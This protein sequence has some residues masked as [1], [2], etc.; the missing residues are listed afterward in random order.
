MP[1]KTTQDL[2]AQAIATL[3]DN[4]AEL[5]TAADVRALILDLLDT[6]APIYGGMSLTSQI[7]VLT[8]APVALPF[9]TNIVDFPTEWTVGLAT[10]EISRSVPPSLPGVV[11]RLHINGSITGPA[12]ADVTVQLYKNGVATPWR[13]EVACRGLSRP[14]AG[15]LT[16]LDYSLVPV[17]YQLRVSSV[18]NANV[19]FL[20]WTFVGEN[21]HLR[22][23]IP[24]VPSGG[25]D[26]GL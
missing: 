1:R 17:T 22:A 4:N 25:F 2:L 14:A 15:I 9:A 12:N 23:N 7:G 18:P 6:I 11:S 13:T 16:V 3:P 24:P 21:I 26:I 10:G 5:I 19:T 8:A 20:N